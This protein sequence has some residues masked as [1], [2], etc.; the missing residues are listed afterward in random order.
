[1]PA[2]EGHYLASALE[3][4]KIGSKTKSGS[5]SSNAKGGHHFASAL[6]ISKIGSKT[7]SGSKSSSSKGKLKKNGKSEKKHFHGAADDTTNTCTS[8]AIPSKSNPLSFLGAL[9][10]SEPRELPTDDFKI[11]RKP[12]PVYPDAHDNYFQPRSDSHVVPS[13]TSCHDGWRFLDR[14]KG[15]CQLDWVDSLLA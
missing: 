9:K 14:A 2:R 5:K 6:R 10:R 11:P 1:M 12:L 13:A 4:S 3:G 7:K 15:Q 8:L